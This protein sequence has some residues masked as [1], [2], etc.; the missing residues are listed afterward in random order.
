M[1]FAKDVVSSTLECVYENGIRNA[2]KCAIIMLELEQI[3]EFEKLLREMRIEVTKR[4]K[5]LGENT[6]ESINILIS[7][8]DYIETKL[9]EKRIKINKEMKDLDDE[10][11]DES[12]E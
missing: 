7:K 6:C 9:T 2:I 10:Q 1:A 8:I 4:Q 5:N 3:T 12:E 11:S